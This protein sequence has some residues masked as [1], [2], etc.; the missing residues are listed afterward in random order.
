MRV[1]RKLTSGVVGDLLVKTLTKAKSS[2]KAAGG[3]DAETEEGEEKTEEGEPSQMKSSKAKLEKLHATKEYEAKLAEMQSKH[4]RELDKLK[5]EYEKNLLKLRDVAL[6]KEKTI[7]ALKDEMGKF[8]RMPNSPG[9]RLMQ[10]GDQQKPDVMPSKGDYTEE[11]L[12]LSRPKGAGKF[13]VFFYN[14]KAVSAS[15]KAK[16][17][18]SPPRAS[19]G[20]P[21]GTKASGGKTTGKKQTQKKQ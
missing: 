10:S 1:L 5:G 2:L 4:K 8:E 21:N 15:S 18:V 9:G 12:V 14:Y 11:G 3:G 16:Q 7:K 20:K 17:S 13:A 19:K 6:D